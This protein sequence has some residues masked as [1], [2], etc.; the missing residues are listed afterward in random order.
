VSLDPDYGVH[1]LRMANNEIARGNLSNALTSLQTAEA[2]ID[3]S[4]AS[5]ELLAEL[6]Y[7]FSRAGSTT[8]ARRIVDEID[9]RSSDIHVGIGARAMSLLALGDYSKAL[10]LLNQS[11]VA[12]ADDGIID[13]S[14]KALAQISANVL[15]DPELE[16]AEYREARSQLT[17]RD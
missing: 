9:S 2:L 1:H 10:V 4:E 14:F 11:I 5:P 16:G 13:G 17:F 15:A 8:D 7:A 3:T 6:A 12:V